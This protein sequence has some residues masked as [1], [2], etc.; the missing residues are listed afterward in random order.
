MRRREARV[1][2]P[3]ATPTQ[4]LQCVQPRE[5]WWSWWSAVTWWS[6]HPFFCRSGISWLTSPTWRDWILSSPIST[7]SRYICNRCLKLSYPIESRK[8]L[9]RDA[10]ARRLGNIRWRS[11]GLQI[12]EIRKGDVTLTKRLSELEFCKLEEMANWSLRFVIGSSTR[13]CQS[14]PTVLRQS[15]QSTR[16]QTQRFPVF[17]LQIMIRNIE[18]LFNT[19]CVCA[20]LHLFLD[21]V[22]DIYH[23]KNILS[24]IVWG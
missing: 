9:I 2:I 24:K 11:W 1:E 20:Y 21:I 13:L 16:I 14:W 7:Y 19:H 23:F 22:C 6:R 18:L 10:M 15:L 4:V 5:Y 17:F 3:N 8:A 12:S